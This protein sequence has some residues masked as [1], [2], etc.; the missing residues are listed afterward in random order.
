[1]RVAQR[2]LSGVGRV[3]D[4]STKDLDFFGPSADD[5]QSLLATLEPALTDAGLAVRRERVTPS[6]VRL[7]VTAD[8]DATE[9]D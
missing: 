5:V 8:D 9:V 1:L 6:F 4:R 7:T 2:S 3:V